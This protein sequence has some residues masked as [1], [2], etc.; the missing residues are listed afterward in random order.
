M[1]LIATCLAQFVERKSAVRKVEG[2]SPRPDQHSATEENALPSEL[3]L[4]MVR[5]HFVGPVFGIFI[6]TW[7]SAG[8]VEEPKHLSKGL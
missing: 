6:V 8:D 2:S 5:C 3:L 4:Q 1:F 7:L